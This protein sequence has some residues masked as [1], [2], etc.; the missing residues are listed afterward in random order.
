MILSVSRRT[1]I[2]AFY[3]EWFFNRLKA[4]YLLVRNP[5][6]FKQVSRIPLNPSDVECIVFWTK[7]PQKMLERLD[8]LKDYNYYFQVTM[9]SYDKSIEAYVPPKKEI[10]ET[11]KRLSQKI[12]SEKTIWRYD[13]IIITDKFSEEYHIKYFEKMAMNLS[14]Y[15]EKCV[16]SFVDFYKKTGK[17]MNAINAKKLTLEDM[18]RIAEQ[19][20]R[21]A[22]KYEI[23]LETCSEIIDLEEFN[24]SH[25]KCIDDRLISRILGIEAT[26][27]KDTN[28]REECGCVKSIDVGIYNTCPHLCKYCYANTSSES[29]MKNYENHCPN[30]E[31]LFGELHGDE[32]IYDRKIDRYFDHVQIELI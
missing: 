19:I 28:Q 22:Q 30:S 27:P 11:F 1:D 16:I 31:L 18:R 8:E 26:I 32:T 14:G 6:N 21:I 17:N 10:M 9:T 20:S 4:G 24:I 25:S 15:T 23:Q 29:A 2:P 12:G 13:P 3:S 7:N 5:M